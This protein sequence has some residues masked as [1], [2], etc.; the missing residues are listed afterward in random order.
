MLCNIL[1]GL[2]FLLL[3]RGKVVGG[4][5]KALMSVHKLWVSTP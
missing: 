5:I 2:H 4:G 3:Q 1:T